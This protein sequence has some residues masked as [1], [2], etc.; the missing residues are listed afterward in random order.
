ME[1]R[2]YAQAVI[3]EAHKRTTAGVLKWRVERTFITATLIG[4]IEI[5]ISFADV[6]PDSAQW[7]F[8]SID[9]PVSPERTV[10]RNPEVSKYPDQVTDASL[11]QMNQIFHQV[12]LDPRRKEFEE[13]MK[14]LS[15]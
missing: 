13:I 15:E 7:E 3:A 8:V 4:K 10:I 6:G 12:L 2:E 11:D 1:K 5:L 9:S 14:K